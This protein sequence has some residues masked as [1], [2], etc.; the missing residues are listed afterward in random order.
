M[1][2]GIASYALM[3]FGLEALALTPMGWG[4]RGMLATAR[5][6]AGFPGAA[7]HFEAMPI[8]AL[9]LIV[10]GG[11][12]FLL[13]SE[14]WRWLGVA[15]V[16]G[17]IALTLLA[18]QPD[19]LVADDGRLVALRLASGEIA[20]SN[21]QHDRFTQ[22]VWVRRDGEGEIEDH[23]PPSLAGLSE[24]G[25][26]GNGMCRFVVNGRTTVI[27]SDAKGLA[28]GCADADLVISQVAAHGVCQAKIVVDA[29]DLARDGA[30]AITMMRHGAEIATVRALTGERPWTEPAERAPEPEVKRT[31]AGWGKTSDGDAV[32][33]TAPPPSP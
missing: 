19:V 33:H 28:A 22:A 13:W 25:G 5:L 20:V 21:R 3:P 1:P 17:G 12:W 11:L 7:G 10:C 8:S 9:A 32:R 30:Y 14:R 29:T 15:P 26:C 31:K 27:V 2:F 23:P 24:P 18:R 4:I 16:A 6:F